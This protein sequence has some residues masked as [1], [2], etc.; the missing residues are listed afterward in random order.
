MNQ[1]PKTSILQLLVLNLGL[2]AAF[3]KTGIV[4]G[5]RAPVVNGLLSVKS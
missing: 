3:Y 1:S 5:L 2:N 4:G